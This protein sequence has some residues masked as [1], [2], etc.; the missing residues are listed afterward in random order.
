MP[1]APGLGGA[2][3]QAKAKAGS[4]DL[5]DISASFHANGSRRRRH[6]SPRAMSH[7]RSAGDM[8]AIVAL[9][10]FGRHQCK[11]R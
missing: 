10:A 5:S 9:T 7:M 11:A 2:P 8:W 6:A 4:L 1:A 3:Q